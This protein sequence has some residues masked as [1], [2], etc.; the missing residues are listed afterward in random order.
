LFVF[1]YDA[2]VIRVCVLT[3][4]CSECAYE[5]CALLDAPVEAF[6]ASFPAVVSEAGNSKSDNDDD[7]DNAIAVA[8][9]P[10]GQ[11]G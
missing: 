9:E 8:V 4:Q 2:P 3:P 11:K 10:A 5:P 1:Y 6:F 7:N